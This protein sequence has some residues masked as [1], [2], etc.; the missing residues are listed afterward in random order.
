MVS[1]V[2]WPSSIFYYPIGNTSAVD[3]TD[4]LAPEEPAH[5]LVLGCGDPRHILFTVHNQSPSSKSVDGGSLRCSVLISCF[6]K[7]NVYL[8]S[9][10][11]MWSRRSWVRLRYGLRGGLLRLLAP[12]SEERATSHNDRRQ[13]Q[14]LREHCGQNV[15]HILPLLPGRGINCTP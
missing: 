6:S 12:H 3:L 2:L 15:E 10:A 9:H 5:V 13:Q 4:T 1:S 8:I 11:A 14:I 7:V